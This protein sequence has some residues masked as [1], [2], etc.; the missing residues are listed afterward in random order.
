MNYKDK[1]DVILRHTLNEVAEE[2]KKGIKDNVDK[3][4]VTSIPFVTISK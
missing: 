3:D 2:M 4:I 1:L